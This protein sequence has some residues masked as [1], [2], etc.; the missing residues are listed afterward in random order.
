MAPSHFDVFLSHNSKDKPAVERIAGLLK[1]AQ[2]EP[3][4][5]VWR[6]TPGGQW[7]SEIEVGLRASRSCAVFV[8]PHGVGDWVRM[9]LAVALDL[10]AHDRDFRLFLVLLPG[11]AE[12]FDPTT[13]PAFLSTRTWIDL[14]G[15]FTEPAQIQ[16]LINAIVGTPLGP[17]TAI[18]PD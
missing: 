4:L 11:L 9:E 6:L 3:W 12:P 10:A 16:P 8:G 2:L 5:D 1:R 7:Q 18:E 14:R 15:G 13:L 17:S